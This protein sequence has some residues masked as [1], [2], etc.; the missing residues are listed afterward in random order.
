MID[1]SDRDLFDDSQSESQ[2]AKRK[3]PEW[4]GSSKPLDLSSTAVKKAKK[5]KG[6][7]N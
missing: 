6:L 1:A 3:L 5:K 2:S 7:F 4:F